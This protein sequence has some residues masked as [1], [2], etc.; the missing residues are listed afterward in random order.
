MTQAYYQ[1][2]KLNQKQVLMEARVSRAVLLPKLG[3]ILITCSIG[4]GGKIWTEELRLQ[5]KLVK[6]VG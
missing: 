5:I 4:K 6:K 1:K 2:N 3:I